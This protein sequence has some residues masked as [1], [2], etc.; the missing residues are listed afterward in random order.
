MLRKFIDWVTA[1]DYALAK[2]AA[3]SQVV[4]RFSRGNV[5]VQAGRILDENSLRRLSRRGDC[6]M[7]RL[8]RVMPS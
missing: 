7:A 5:L 3:T 8:R 2:Q 1:K 6:A 4:A